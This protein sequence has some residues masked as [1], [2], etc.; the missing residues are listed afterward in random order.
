LNTE[1]TPISGAFTVRKYR[2]LHGVSTNTTLEGG[3]FGFETALHVA[4]YNG[5]MDIVKLLLEHGADPNIYSEKTSGF[6]WMPLTRNRKATSMG[7]RCK[8]HRIL[9]SW[10][11]SSSF[12]NMEQTQISGTF[13]W[14]VTVRRYLS[15]CVFT[16][17]TLQAHLVDF[18]TAL[19]VAAHEKNLDVIKLL[20]EHEADP[21]VRCNRSEEISR[22]ARRF[23]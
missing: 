12:L 14:T 15:P 7:L 21:N 10:I 1:R 8:Q 17:T 5:N 9:Y 11:S 16:N 20:L 6:T 3:P 22:P 23:H 2:S 4:V 18:E 13:T 19:Y